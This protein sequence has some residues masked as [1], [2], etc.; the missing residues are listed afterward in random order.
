VP[1]GERAENEGGFWQRHL[2]KIGV[3][4]SLFAALG[5]LGFP[6]LLSI[7]SA[8]GLGFLVRDAVLIPLLVVFLILT[9]IGLLFGMRHHHQPWV[10]VL[11]AVSAAVTFVSIGLK[12]SGIFAA[13]GVAVLIAASVLNVWLR[14]Q[15][16][17]TR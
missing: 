15:Q 14:S 16:L 7:V 10:L 9:L 1:I 2:D 12:A 13:I 4:G 8:L 11:G 6:A 5:C 3:G 17:R